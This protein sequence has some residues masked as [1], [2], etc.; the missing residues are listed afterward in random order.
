MRNAQEVQHQDDLRKSPHQSQKV[1]S[2]K[3]CKQPSS[4]KCLSK[5]PTLWQDA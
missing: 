1:T 4:L 2:Q 3:M 5:L